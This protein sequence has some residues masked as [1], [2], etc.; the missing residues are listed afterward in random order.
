MS[1]T[2][3]RNG[4]REL[5]FR[6]QILLAALTVAGPAVVLWEAGTVAWAWFLLGAVGF[7]VTFGPFARTATGQAVDDWFT[8]IGVAGRT[9]CIVAFALVVWTV[10]GSVQP[11]PATV[12]SFAVGGVI[13]LTIVALAR[14]V[15]T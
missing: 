6:Y 11:D 10:M 7:G 9:V 3:E 2:T 13:A 15:P 5:R 4:G 8:R 1:P 14:R 12:G